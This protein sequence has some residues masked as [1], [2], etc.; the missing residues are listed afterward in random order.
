MNKTVLILIDGLRSDAIAQ[1]ATPVLDVLM[2]T[3]TACLSG[4]TV[5][6]SLTLPVHFS[7]F[8]SLPPYSHGVVTNTATPDMS[9][10]VQSLF[11]H[12]KAQ[13][14]NTAAF[15]SWDH[16]RNLAFPGQVDYTLIQRVQS[17][18][19]QE[20]LVTAAARHLITHR[21]DFTFVYLEWADLM[22]HSHGW[23]S[24]PY[25]SAVTQ[26]DQ[27]AGKVVDAV[28]ILEKKE[29]PFN[30]V[31]MSDHG[32]HETHHL[33]SHPDTRTIPFIARGKSVRSGMLLDGSLSVLDIAP[34]L[35]RM[36][37]IRPHPGW[38]GNVLHDL[39]RAGLE[40]VPMMH[41]G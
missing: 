32:G 18:K 5:E 31:V 40:R 36:M 22:G 11:A 24:D 4:Q 3:G 34:T 30:I 27:A 33:L 15:Y 20:L 19:D 13:G 25:L 17:P 28:R 6:P 23:M 10:A 9:G 35:T 8:T 1:T 39:F 41:L 29:M 37:D 14:G 16:L 38:Q 2:E 12:I 7:I 21:P 26:C